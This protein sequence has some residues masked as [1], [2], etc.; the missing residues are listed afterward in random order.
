M[1]PLYSLPTVKEP[2]GKSQLSNKR[3][4]QTPGHEDQ[5][6]QNGKNKTG[7]AKS[8]SAEKKRKKNWDQKSQTETKGCL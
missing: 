3:K 7:M 2:T 1:A 4:S 8:W 5:A 6:W